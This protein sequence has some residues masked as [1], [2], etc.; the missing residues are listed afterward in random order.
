MR[1]LVTAIYWWAFD[2]HCPY[3]WR[4]CWEMAAPDYDPVKLGV[5]EDE[6]RMRFGG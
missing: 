5:E 1:R 2:R 4:A 3:T 6:H